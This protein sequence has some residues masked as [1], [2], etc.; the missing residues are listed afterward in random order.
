MHLKKFWKK[1]FIYFVVPVLKN[2]NRQHLYAKTKH[3][4]IY[5]P[6]ECVLEG[7]KNIKNK[8]NRSDVPDAHICISSNP[9]PSPQSCQAQ[10]AGGKSYLVLIIYLSTEDL[11]R[12]LGKASCG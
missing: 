6:Q 7:V 11:E 12:A 4:K 9:I 3:Q 5:L 8:V 1:T 10:L 2:N